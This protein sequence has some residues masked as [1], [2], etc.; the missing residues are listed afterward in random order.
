MA[1]KLMLHMV[2]TCHR[3]ECGRQTDASHGTH[4]P[5][6]GR[7]GSVAD[8]THRGHSRKISVFLI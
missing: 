6:E 3:R 4:L 2:L 8:S 5:R 1:D 7:L